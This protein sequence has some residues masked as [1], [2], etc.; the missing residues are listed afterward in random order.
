ME[1]NSHQRRVL[2]TTP[3]SQLRSIVDLARCEID[4]AEFEKGMMLTV[5]NRGDIHLTKQQ[6][7]SPQGIYGII[8]HQVEIWLCGYQALNRFG[9]P[10]YV[11]VVLR[12]PQTQ[13]D[14]HLDAWWRRL[15]PGDETIA[16]AIDAL[17]ISMD[18]YRQVYI[19]AD[20][21]HP[22]GWFIKMLAERPERKKAFFVA[23]YGIRNPL[24]CRHC[25]RSFTKNVSSSGE[26]ILFPF[27][28][29]VSLPGFMDGKCAN[30]IWSS[31]STCTWK[32]LPGY[33]LTLED[34][35]RVDRAL[36]GKDFDD[37]DEGTYSVDTLNIISAPRISSWLPYVDDDGE[38]IQ[39]LA[40]D[41]AEA[42]SR[43]LKGR[44]FKEC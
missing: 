27:H 43:Q 19:P 9:A 18:R 35:G 1:M 17:P 25:V 31:D 2:S 30:C 16:A 20:V 7:D 4:E 40:F 26:H 37:G 29:C 41:D 8:H 39:Q 11:E 38:E 14:R 21:G 5:K 42:T 13:L 36:W 28:A 10:L 33:R 23:F 34:G 22:R 6:I 15:T 44:G 12:G 32:Y 3:R 24:C